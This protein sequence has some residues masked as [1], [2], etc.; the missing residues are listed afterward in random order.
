MTNQDQ[1]AHIRGADTS[2]AIAW[3]QTITGIPGD[4]NPL[5]D[6][7]GEFASQ[8]D[9]GDTIYLA[10]SF[11]GDVTRAFDVDFGDKI[12]IPLVNTWS[13]KFTATLDDL[14]EDILNFTEEI[15]IT[16]VVLRV[17]IGNDGS[18]E[19]DE[20]FDVSE[21]TYFPEIDFPPGTKDAREFFVEPNPGDKFVFEFPDN[22]TLGEDFPA[23]GGKTESYTTGYYA[24]IKGLP[25][26][27]HKLEFGG[28]V[29]GGEAEFSVTDIINVINP[30]DRDNDHP[31]GND[32]ADP[33]A[34]ESA[35]HGLD[36]VPVEGCDWI[37]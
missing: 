9:V 36:S 15:E 6:T 21:V 12:I 2:Q 18:F 29:L 13:D 10:G 32:G 14:R 26:G 24:A 25:K 22:L 11:V 3:V 27:E 8:A 37:C 7:T 30:T 4:V 34:D 35:D 28:T 17:D 31:D 1:Q 33:C 20:A 5:L 19:F 23:E 16:E